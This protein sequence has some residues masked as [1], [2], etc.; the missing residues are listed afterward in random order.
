MLLFE[1]DMTYL[2]VQTTLL[3]FPLAP[4]VML[5]IDG[6]DRLRHDSSVEFTC[7]ALETYIPFELK[8]NITDSGIDYLDDLE[9]NSLIT[10][11]PIVYTQ[12][13]DEFGYS[14]FF[15]SPHI[16]YTFQ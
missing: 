9:T 8:L 15:I 1:R 6:P 13:E 12:Y 2:T 7:S 11:S 16:Q 5:S 3:N 4:P 10:I 14:R